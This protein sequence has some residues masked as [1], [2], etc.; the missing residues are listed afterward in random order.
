MNI[1]KIEQNNVIITTVSMMAV[2]GSDLLSLQ[3]QKTKAIKETFTVNYVDRFVWSDEED[4][5]TIR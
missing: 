5:M 3:L 2:V 4:H 1:R